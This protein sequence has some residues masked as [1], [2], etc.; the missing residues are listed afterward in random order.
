MSEEQ[1]AETP[2]ER[3]AERWHEWFDTRFRTPAA[4]YGL[5]LYSSLLMITA[6]YHE[7]VADAVIASVA[8]LV[9]FFISHVF[10]YTLADH[11]R[12]SLRAATL[13]SL[14]H[15]AGMLWASIPPTIAMLVAGA[16]GLNADDSSVYALWTTMLVLAFLG[17]VAYW[18]TGARVWARIL[19]A[20]GT[21]L[22]GAVVAILEYAFH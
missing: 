22:L 13:Y 12:H 19:G 18:R 1:T 7:G 9:V 14:T 17:Y 3:R 8:T 21:S 15:S 2:E 10:A 16:N 4:V 11:G 5:I 6:D 20:I